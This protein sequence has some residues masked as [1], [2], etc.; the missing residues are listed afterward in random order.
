MTSEEPGVLVFRLGSLGDT[1]IALPALFAI[2]SHF[3]GASRITLLRDVSADKETVPEDLLAGH[4]CISDFMMYP[5]GANGWTRWV[6]FWRLLKQV[7]SKRF[8]VVVY[9]GPSRRSVGAQVRDRLFF[10]LC[11]IRRLI[12]FKRLDRNT[13]YPRSADG[14]PGIVQQEA[15]FL[16][17]RLAADGIDEQRGRGDFQLPVDLELTEEELSTALEWIQ[18]RRNHP[19]RP[20]VAVA[21]GVNQPANQWPIAHFSEVGRLLLRDHLCEL[22]VVGGPKDKAFGEFLVREWASGINCAGSFGPRLS[23]ALLSH[24]NLFLG[25]DSGPMHL[26]AMV[27]VPC[28]CLFS[29]RDNPGRWHPIGEGHCVIRKSVPCGGCRLSVCNQKDHPCMSAISVEEVAEAVREQLSF[30]EMTRKV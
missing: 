19:D 12:G 28:V 10:R 5:A 24:C 15:R 11:G 30:F 29:D 22:I 3:G 9:L 17:D 4:S 26:A 14:R 18:C 7:R 6:S 23:A 21:P 13:L 2:R 8:D 20:L 27:G 25:L 1:V 16:L